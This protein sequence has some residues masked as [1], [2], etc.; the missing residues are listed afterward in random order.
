[1]WL[2]V[3][4]NLGCVLGRPPKPAHE[5][6]VLWQVSNKVLLGTRWE[7]AG[8]CV[9]KQS[10][11]CLATTP[12]VW[13]RTA[14]T[15]RHS[16]LKYSSLSFLSTEML[17]QPSHWLF[18]KVRGLILTHGNI[19]N[20]TVLYVSAS[21][22]EEISNAFSI[23]SFQFVSLQLKISHINVLLQLLRRSSSGAQ[24]RNARQANPLEFLLLETS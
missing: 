5:Y 10:A 7:V 6:F 1:M 3:D 11:G 16:C 20:N 24:K 15:L 14:V 12:S 8:F 17:C 21:V 22:W 23:F 19:R 18:L 4:V 2:A 13:D 9:Y